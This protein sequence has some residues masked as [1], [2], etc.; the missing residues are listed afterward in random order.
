LQLWVGAKQLDDALQLGAALDVPRHHAH[1]VTRRR[2]GGFTGFA[3]LAQGGER[4]DPLAESR[5]DLRAG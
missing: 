2:G 1:A 5:V 3:A 4:I